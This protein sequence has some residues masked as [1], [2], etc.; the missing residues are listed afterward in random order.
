MDTFG[1]KPLLWNVF[2]MRS[3]ACQITFILRF[4]FPQ[5]ICGD[6]IG[7]LK[8]ASSHHINKSYCN[9]SFLW[10]AEYGVFTFSRYIN[11]QKKHHADNTLDTTMENA[12]LDRDSP[13]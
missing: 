12:S 13:L 10:Q 8:G 2:R 7:R 3:A 1:A 9:G 4:P 11:N 5:I 6:L